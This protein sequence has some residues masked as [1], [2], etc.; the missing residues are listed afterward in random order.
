MCV[1]VPMSEQTCISVAGAAA[2]LG[3]GG[4]LL[5]LFVWSKSR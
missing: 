1:D 4:G 5:L 2:E 3:D